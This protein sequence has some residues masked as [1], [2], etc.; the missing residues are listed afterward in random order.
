MLNAGPNKKHAIGMEC[1][2]SSPVFF[3]TSIYPHLLSTLAR[4]PTKNKA[5][6]ALAMPDQDT[7]SGERPEV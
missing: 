6:K 1:D 3:S 5:K 4:H 7:K 2:V